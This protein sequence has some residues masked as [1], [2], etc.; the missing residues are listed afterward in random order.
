MTNARTVRSTRDKAAELR[1]EAAR[2]EAR[3]RSTLIAVVVAVVLVVVVGATV[4][5]V[6]AAPQVKGMKKSSPWSAA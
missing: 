2:K 3:R 6:G 5:V 1:A 4:V